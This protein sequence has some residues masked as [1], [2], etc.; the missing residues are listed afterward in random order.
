L[1][2]QA[3]LLWVQKNIAVFGGDPKKVTI[4]GESAGS[5]GVSTLMAS[6]LSKNL[7]AGAIGESGAAI[8][9][10]MAPV[11]LSEGERQGAEFL[12][13]A[14]IASVAELRKLSTKAIYEIYNE[15]R[16]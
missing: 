6:P 8:N 3:A 1:D 14:N 2:Q 16:R 4:A 11:P 5:I 7:I 10:T 15:S 13:S 9:P 12:K